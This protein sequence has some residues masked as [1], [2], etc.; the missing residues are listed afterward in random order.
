MKRIKNTFHEQTIS[1]NIKNLKY[2]VK[3]KFHDHNDTTHSSS[4][5]QDKIKTFKIWILIFPLGLSFLIIWNTREYS[6]ISLACPN[7]SKQRQPIQTSQR[8]PLLVIDRVHPKCYKHGC[9]YGC[10]TPAC[11]LSQTLTGTSFIS[12]IY[13]P[14]AEPRIFIWVVIITPH[15]FITKLNF[16]II[17]N[18]IN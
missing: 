2:Q 8:Q 16:L 4:W 7:N 3:P 17:I 5:C 15:L 6:A 10:T 12:I 1:I 14:K 11:C 13:R 9:G 18:I